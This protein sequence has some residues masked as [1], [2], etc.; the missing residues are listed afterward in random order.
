[1]K[2]D[3]VKENEFYSKPFSFSFS[4][5][6]RLLFSPSIFYKEYILKEREIKTDSFLVEGKL[7]HCLIFQPEKFDEFFSV[8]PGKVPSA[9]IKK[10]LKSVTLHTDV[11]VLAEVE[12]FIILDSLKEQDL[13]QSLKTDESRVAKVKTDDAEE[14][15]KFMC[16]TG[17]D[18]I[19][20]D[21]LARCKDKAQIIKDNEDIMLLFDKGRTDFELDTLEVYKEQPLECKLEAHSFGLKGIV[22][23]YDIDHEKREINIVD[24]KTSGKSLVDFRETVDYY[25]L[26][27]Q[28]AIYCKLVLASHEG[29]EDYKIFFTFVVIDKYNQVFPFPVSQQTLMD[30]AH[31][32]SLVLVEAQWHY[33]ERNYT[34]PWQF[35]NDKIVL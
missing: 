27:L 18:I 2:I 33:Q 34:L 35:L 14:Y 21:M 5:L 8:V 12:D 1:M 10:V 29:I 32:T 9:N 13:Y 28:C 23:Y 4:S 17:K 30:W 16:T 11:P 26:W 20:N 25:N 3:K 31:A 22:D 6:N 15:Y 19:D 7:V 24:L